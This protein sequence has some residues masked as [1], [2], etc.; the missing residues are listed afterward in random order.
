[1]LQRRALPVL[2]LVVVSR[3]CKKP[4]TTMS[5]TTTLFS[6][7]QRRQCATLP[8]PYHPAHCLANKS[9]VCVGRQRKRGFLS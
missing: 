3:R 9:G 5:V 2:V 7:S 1:M 6:P 8:L 4:T